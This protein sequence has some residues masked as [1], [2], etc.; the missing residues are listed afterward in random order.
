M[1][2]GVLWGLLA[3]VF[4]GAIPCAFTLYG[5]RRGRYG[6]RHVRVRE[7]RAVPL[8]ALV[9]AILAGVVAT[10]TVTMWWKISVHPAVA[11]ATAVILPLVFGPALL[12]A[13]SEVAMVGWSRVRLGHHTIA[14]VVAGAV[15]DAVV[16]GSVFPALR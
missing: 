8:L 13:R 14:Q 1:P 6:D 15:L 4:A 16:A 5:V 9:V 11:S 2:R 12:A 3:A 7:E 10:F